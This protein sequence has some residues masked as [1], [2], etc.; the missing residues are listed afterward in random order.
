VLVTGLP[1]ALVRR[2][3]RSCDTPL[4]AEAERRGW[5]RV[6]KEKGSQAM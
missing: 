3:G 4:R 6:T 2:P 5:P 1:P